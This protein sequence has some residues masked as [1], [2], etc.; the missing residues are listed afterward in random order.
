MIYNAA[1]KML[2]LRTSRKWNALQ[3]HTSPVLTNHMS[4]LLSILTV[5]ALSSCS[6]E[7]IVTAKNGLNSHEITASQS[8]SIFNIVKVFPNS[9]EI[10]IV[11]I[12]HGEPKFIGVKRVKDTIFSIENKEK[13]FEIGSI[14]KVFTSTLLTNFVEEGK[15]ELN[16]PIQDYL[17]FQVNL[18]EK[19]TF[20]ELANHT[21]GLPRLPNNLNLFTT[22]PNNPYKNYDTEKLEEYFTEEIEIKQKPGTKYEYS[23]LG[24]GTLGY[25]LTM[26]ANTSYEEL[27]AEM[28]FSKYG[29][30]NTTTNRERIKKNLITGLDA[31]GDNATNWD[32]NVLVG[33]G[34][35]LSS[36]EDM[37][38]FAIAQFNDDN[39]ELLLTQQP[40]FRINEH[41]KIGLG[42]H[43]VTT[44]SS[45]E[46]ICHNG[47]TGGYSS[48]IALDTKNKSGVIILSNIS[49]NNRQKETIDKLCF[50]LIETMDNKLSQ[51]EQVTSTS[52]I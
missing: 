35:I 26:L 40:T 25:S 36:A 22:N 7:E 4:K 13:I 3:K 32:F 49:P 21:S 48:S 38:K 34:G 41:M 45:K 42:W 5:I 1:L 16:D 46:V 12:E 52:P 47:K 18:N 37:S 50:A 27:L 11:I 15:L 28:I 44:R 31:D 30:L 43:I 14:S 9:T 8:D 23:N 19:I 33:A 39:K 10:S 29:M 24:A 17:G 6:K 2:G 51:H 20:Q